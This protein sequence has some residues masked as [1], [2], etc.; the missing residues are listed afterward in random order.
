MTFG[1]LG[2]GAA[3][4]SGRFFRHR[5][6]GFS[7]AD[8]ITYT[9]MSIGL[10]VV[11]M[12]IGAVI[13]AWW[14]LDGAPYK[15]MPDIDDTW[16]TRILMIPS[17]SDML[18]KRA[19]L[20]L[21]LVLLAG[22]LD[23]IDG[24]IARWRG[25]A[26]PRGE[27]LDGMADTVAFGM[28][29]AA[30]L[31]A[32]AVLAQVQQQHLFDHGAR[33]VG[34]L[35]SFGWYPFIWM[36]CGLFVGAMQWRLRASHHTG[37]THFVFKGL[38]APGA[39]LIL[40]TLA[41]LWDTALFHNAQLTPPGGLADL[42]AADAARAVQAVVDNSSHYVYLGLFIPLALAVY[43]TSPIPAVKMNRAGPYQ[44]ALDALILVAFAVVLALKRNLILGFT[45]ALA[46]YIGVGL[47]FGIL[48]LRQNQRKLRAQS[49][50][51]GS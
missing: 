36:A 38:P 29:P 27:D 21:L 13:W 12:N 6:F 5:R 35:P 7:V 22:L 45:A 15:T 2:T 30:T 25:T 24:P 46:T 32:T 40:G 43:M 42:N 17:S 47:I 37:W 11:A 48:L 49:N 14:W 8:V 33:V 26:A 4:V 44:L 9:Y 34:G 3:G 39:G 31:W 23:G 10:L 51:A 18:Q 50:S 20:S 1:P 41:V 28:A 19:G 16:L